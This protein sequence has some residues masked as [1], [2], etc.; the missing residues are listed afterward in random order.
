[1]V[2]S[3]ILL[4]LA[5]EIPGDL[6]PAAPVINKSRPSTSARFSQELTWT[7]GWQTRNAPQR[8]YNSRTPRNVRDEVSVH[9]I[10]V[11]AIGTGPLRLVHLVA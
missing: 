3:G 10:D 8:L 5:F 11:Y 4:K 2:G 9:H 7:S 1:M 6:A